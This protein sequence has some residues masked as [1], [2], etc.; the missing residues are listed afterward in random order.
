MYVYI[1]VCVY[2]HKCIHT[3]V[4]THTY[5]SIIKYIHTYIRIYIHTY[6]HTYI[7]IYIHTHTYIHIYV[8][9]PAGSTFHAAPPSQR[10]RQGWRVQCKHRMLV[11]TCAVCASHLVPLSPPSRCATLSLRK[12]HGWHLQTRK[13]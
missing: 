11:R 3:H 10:Q 12:L 4:Y 8:S 7:H 13:S 5:I 9:S 6:I 1:R 2:T